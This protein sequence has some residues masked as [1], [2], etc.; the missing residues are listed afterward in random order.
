METRETISVDARTQHRCFVLGHVRDG[1]LSAEEAARVLCLSVRQVR[2]LLGQLR[3][4]GVAGLVHGNAGRVPVNRTSEPL[5]ARVLELAT[6]TYAGVNRAHL[7]DLLAEHEDLA[8]P[9][10][11]LRRV[12]AEAGLPPARRRR[13]G[14]HRVRR[15]RMPQAGQ[16]LQV[17]GSRHRWLG[18]G[19]P[20]LTLVGAIDDA[21]GIVTAGT[22]RA[23]EDAAGYLAVLTRTVRDFGRPMAVYSDRHTIFVAER[24]RAPSLAEQLSG[25]EPRTQVGRALEQ[26]GIGWIGARS[27][28]AKGRVERLWRT[29]Q[30]RLVTELRLAG[31]RSIG[32]AEAVLADYLPRHNAR[33][34]VAPA[35]PH[36]AWRGW[37]LSDPVECVFCFHHPRRVA[38]DATVSWAGRALALP[39]PAH[40]SWAGRA[41][42]LEQHLD[43]SLWVGNEGSHHPLSRAPDGPVLLRS[44][45][46]RP[47]AGR[48][49]DTPDGP[50]G[51]G[52]S[53]Y[54]QRPDHP[55]RRPLG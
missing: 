17:D 41:V 25:R 31:A 35:D 49:D 22:F 48:L 18:P 7:A 29:L 52:R 5:R 15:E 8:M 2:R 13:P 30:D 3:A 51:R 6:T 36:G 12:L 33:F 40:G 27:P 10:R 42:V 11:S 20:F 32:D 38:N 9:Q 47:A 26:A 39:R 19:G 44:R 1:T 16:L 23:Q 37:D 34:S 55:W 45:M 53:G 4:D 50:Q 24:P 43:G 28:Q 54:A 14:R 21:T 46:R